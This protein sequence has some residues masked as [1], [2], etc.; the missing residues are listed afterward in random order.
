MPAR[1]SAWCSWR[2]MAIAI[3]KPSTITATGNASGRTSARTGTVT[4]FIPKPIAPWIVAPAMVAIAATTTAPTVT[5]I[6][7]S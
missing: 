6:R 5:S 2:N 4:R 3:P 1:S 7:V